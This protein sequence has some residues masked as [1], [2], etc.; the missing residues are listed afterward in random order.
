MGTVFQENKNKE[1]LDLTSSVSNFIS[2]ITKKENSGADQD[3]RKNEIK[4]D[5]FL[6]LITGQEAFVDTSIAMYSDDRLEELLD[7]MLD[8]IQMDRKQ[9]R[10]STKNRN[11]IA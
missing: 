3:A 1:D 11:A 8:K 7:D 2:T 6:G 10:T 4:S 5:R 9:E